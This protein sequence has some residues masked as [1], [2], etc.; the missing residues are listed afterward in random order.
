MQITFSK[1]AT[2]ETF[3]GVLRD[4]NG[5][6]VQVTRHNGTTVLGTLGGFDNTSEPRIVLVP[7]H[8]LTLPDVPVTIADIAKVEIQ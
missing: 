3:A 4:L 6:N 7:E 5:W 1:E 8:D 2:E